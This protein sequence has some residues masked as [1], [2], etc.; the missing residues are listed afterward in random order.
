MKFIYCIMLA[1]NLETQF[2][3]RCAN[4]A[5]TLKINK[6]QFSLIYM[7][8]IY[9]SAFS[10]CLNKEETIMLVDLVWSVYACSWQVHDEDIEFCC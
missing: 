5:T 3:T 7:F 1:L 10:E 8:F 9:S 6:H 4:Q 2:M